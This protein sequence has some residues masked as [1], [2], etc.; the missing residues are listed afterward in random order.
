VIDR[1]RLHDHPS[2]RHTDDINDLA[3][4]CID[5]PKPVCGHIRKGVRRLDWVAAKKCCTSHG[6]YIDELPI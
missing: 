4:E 1:H 3:P 5:K 6:F 2:H